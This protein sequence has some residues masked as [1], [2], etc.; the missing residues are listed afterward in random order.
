MQSLFQDFHYPYK[1][2]LHKLWHKTYYIKTKFS[3]CELS[4]L[5]LRGNRNDCSALALPQSTFFRTCADIKKSKENGNSGL[6]NAVLRKVA[7]E[8]VKKLLE[9]A[10]PYVKYSVSE[11]IYD[12]L[13][14][15]LGAKAT[16]R[17]LENSLSAP[18]VFI[19]TNTTKSENEV[20][21]EQLKNSGVELVPTDIYNSFIAKGIGSIENINAYKSGLIYV[22][23]FSSSVC[24]MTLKAKEGM[25]VLDACAAP[26]G[27]SFSIALEMKNK[28][29][30]VSCDIHEHRVKLISN[31]AKRLG[32]DCVNPTL[33]DATIF[34]DGLGLFD[35]VL[36]DVP[37]SGIG[38][39]R[40]KPEI[41]YKNIKEFGEL[42]E[43]QFKI[44][45]TAAK[46]LKKGGRLIYSTCTLL[47]KENEEVVERFLKENKDFA[48]AEI[49]VLGIKEKVKTFLPPD[50]LGDGFF[51][52]ALERK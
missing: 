48:L 16:E 47:K 35:R 18:P 26:G 5:C 2:P 50:C 31:G 19:K 44:L 23:D 46:Y 30:I 49:E 6:V 4:Q 37:C 9:N 51:I 32:L 38:V 27:K 15:D 25:R 8:D 42:P 33:L 22:Q 10:E 29:E 14:K 24:S 40:R 20:I 41:K 17:F 11:E 36:C 52:A 39:I 34:D 43:I 7:L 45:S 21:L 13:L 12:A 28:G 1:I 3:L